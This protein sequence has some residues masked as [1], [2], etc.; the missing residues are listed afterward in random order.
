MQD[1]ADGL[2]LGGAQ[3]SRRDAPTPRRS[4]R[5]ATPVQRGPADG[6]RGARGRGADDT[7]EVL[8]GVHQARSSLSWAFRGGSQGARRL[9]LDL[10]HCLHPLE[11]S[12]SIAFSRSELRDPR[13]LRRGRGPALARRQPRLRDAVPLS[14][15]R[16]KVGRVQPLSSKDRPNAAG[17]LGALDLA[18]DAK[19]VL[20]REPPALGLRLHGR[21]GRLGRTPANCISRMGSICHLLPALY[22]KLTGVSVSHMLAQRA[23]A[24]PPRPDRAP[25]EE[26]RPTASHAW[27]PSIIS[28][29]PSTLN[30]RG[31]VSHT[32]WHRGDAEFLFHW[33]QTFDLR[34][35]TAPGPTPQLNKKDL[36]PVLMP[37]PGDIDEQRE[38]AR[39][40]SHV[41]NKQSHHQQKKTALTDLFRTLLH[42][43]MTAQIRVNDLSLPELETA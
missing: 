25:P 42:Q 24:S 17:L 30:S 34:K 21:I 20:R 43:L 28:S 7:G 32:C 22:T 5:P 15:P 18:Q 2:A 35:I 10:D 11:A 37:L 41:D 12:P 6:Q 9:F 14:T 19:L 23:G 27:D 13:V 38:I 16:H 1:V 3:G 8:R 4:R 36:I 26:P 40:I 39:I 33:Q 29:P 31:S